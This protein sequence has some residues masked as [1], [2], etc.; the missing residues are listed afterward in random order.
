MDHDRCRRLVGPALLAVTLAL[1]ASA[2][3]D[4]RAPLDPA[5]DPEAPPGACRAAAGAATSPPPVRP[6]SCWRADDVRL[7]RTSE[8]QDVSGAC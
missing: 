6:S 3:G 7:R 1:P 2:C 4:T 5:V 8:C